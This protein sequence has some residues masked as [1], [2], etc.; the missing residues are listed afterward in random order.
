MIWNQRKLSR[1]YRSGELSPGK[2]GIGD[3]MAIAPNGTGFWLVS[4]YELA[5]NVLADPRFSRSEAA[6][7]KAPKLT[8]HNAAPNAII[9]TEGAVHTR[10]RQLVAPAFTERRIAK[11]EPVV[12]RIVEDLLDELDAQNS[13]ADFVSHVSAP[14]PFAALCR[15]LGVP[16]SDREIFGSWVNVLFRLT[17][18]AAEM[19]QA[20]VGPLARYMMRLVADKGAS[21]PKT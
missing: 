19:R 2:I 16:P 21:P 1:K 13:P 15:L 10:M 20:S 12:A 6:G 18:D 9:S 4:D 14:L 17:G 11:L 3:T 5:R 7:P 8:A